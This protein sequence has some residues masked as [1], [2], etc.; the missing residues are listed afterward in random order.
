MDWKRMM[1]EVRK[2]RQRL[3]ISQAKM[4]KAVGVL[5]S[6]TNAHERLKWCPRSSILLAYMNYLREYPEKKKLEF[7]EEAKRPN[8]FAQ[9]LQAS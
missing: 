2:E 7:Q 8:P 6:T 9:V 3:G 1:Q 4:A 5:T